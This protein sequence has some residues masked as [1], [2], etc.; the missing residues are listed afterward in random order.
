ML[1]EL[2]PQQHERLRQVFRG[3]DTRLHGCVEAIFSGAFAKVWVDDPDDPRAALVLLDFWFVAGD[4]TAPAAPD[5]ARAAVGPG[6]VVTPPGEA[7]PDLLR[8]ASPGRVTE[9]TRWAFSSPEAWDVE[10]LRAYRD[11]LPSGFT[12]TRITPDNVGAYI[13]CEKALLGT[14]PSAET[15]MA[16]G[17]G[18]GVEREGRFV[19]GCSS[20]TLAGGKLEF[21]IQTNAGWR[22]HGL[23]TAAGAA[24]VLHCLDHGLEPCWDAHNEMSASLADKLGFTDKSPY[25]VCVIEA[26]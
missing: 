25:T 1:V 22:R 9:R 3:W 8:E 10:R 14:F 19:A 23:A 17:V 18:Y 12:L 4:A 15:L 7:W 11:A 2:P 20:F 6:T 24:M 13:A 5:V 26:P 21:E 16:R